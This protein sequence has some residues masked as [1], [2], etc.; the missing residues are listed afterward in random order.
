MMLGCLAVFITCAVL[1]VRY[2]ADIASS[3]QTS[4][5]LRAIYQEAATEEVTQTPVANATVAPAAE[6]LKS[7]APLRL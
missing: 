4:E 7:S 1:L 2:F 3:M 5:E 6:M